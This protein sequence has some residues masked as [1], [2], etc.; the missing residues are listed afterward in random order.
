VSTVVFAAL[1]AVLADPLGPVVADIVALG[2]CALANTAANRRLTFSLRGRADR[3][4]QYAAGLAITLM[5]LALTL[6]ALALLDAGGVTALAPQLIAL[7]SVNALA[8]ACRFLLLRTWV[9]RA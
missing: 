9:F 8:T 5:P 2:L 3:T 1:F 4:R 6:G 7:T